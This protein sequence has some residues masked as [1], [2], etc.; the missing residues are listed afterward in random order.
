MENRTVWKC[1]HQG[2]K[3]KTFIQTDRRGRDGHPGGEDSRQHSG[4]QMDPE[5]W[6]IAE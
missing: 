3:E 1:D 6:W 5:M 2:D 4:W